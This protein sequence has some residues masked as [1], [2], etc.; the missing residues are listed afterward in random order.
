M[1]SL[2]CPNRARA[3][4]CRYVILYTYILIYVR[5]VY[6]WSVGVCV[7]VFVCFARTHA[8]LVAIRN[9]K[10]M[11]IKSSADG[12]Y[13]V[14]SIWSKTTNPLLANRREKKTQ[15][16]I[17]KIDCAPRTRS[18]RKKKWSNR[19]R[20]VDLF[21]FFLS[22]YY[23]IH[24]SRPWCVSTVWR[25]HAPNDLYTI[26]V[27]QIMNTDLFIYLSIILYIVYIYC[28]LLHINVHVW[29]CQ[30]NCHNS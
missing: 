20:F 11:I 14:C 2:I 27:P 21:S 4:I 19:P 18:Q 25:R 16:W 10:K 5:V 22:S 30:S 13:Y 28:L 12:N 23:I 8:T 17:K 1:D 15:R 26:H 24:H 29:L 7:C 9:K 3:H 6:V